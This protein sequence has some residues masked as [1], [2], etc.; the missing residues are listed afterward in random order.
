MARQADLVWEITLA[1]WFTDR[2]GGQLEEDTRNHIVSLYFCMFYRNASVITWPFHRYFWNLETHFIV[3]TGLP[4]LHWGVLCLPC[5][6]GQVIEPRWELRK[7]LY[8]PF[9]I[10]RVWNF[11]SLIAY[12]YWIKKSATI[13]TKES[14]QNQKTGLPR[15]LRGNPPANMGDETLVRSP[16]QEDPTWLR[17]AKPMSATTEPGL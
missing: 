3:V 14:P 10:F 13:I 16:V 15:W 1:S 5:F 17:A 9:L 2:I 11:N 8:R 6:I 12:W 7:V 4:T